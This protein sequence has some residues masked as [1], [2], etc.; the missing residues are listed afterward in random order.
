MLQNKHID[1]IK[2]GIYS[3]V[4]RKSKNVKKNQ[5][6]ITKDKRQNPN[7]VRWRYRSLKRIF[8]FSPKKETL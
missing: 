4:G 5:E 3:L 8:L 1:K 7:M 2:D 6:T